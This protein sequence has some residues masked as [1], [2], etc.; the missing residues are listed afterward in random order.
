MIVGGI[1]AVVVLAVVYFLF[2]RGGDN[3]ITDALH[4][5][6]PA[7]PVPDFA[8]K[9]VTSKYEATQARMKKT[10]L[11]KA[12]KQ[13][14]PAVQDVIT[15]VLQAGYV[16]PDTWG[17]KGAI[18][19]YFTDDAAGQI[20]AK[21]N[22]LTLGQDVTFQT[23]TPSHNAKLKV[24]T[25]LDGNMQAVRAYGEFTFKAK[26]SNEDGSS[27]KIQLTGTF[28]LVPD[29]GDWKIEAF[30]LSR[31]ET[32]HKAHSPSGSA[33]GTGSPTATGSA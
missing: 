6:S 33:S 28:F 5:T 10:A 4:I 31:S 12:A 21:I 27:S 3:P 8:F 9:T 26:A 24:T 2:G 32:P 1:A 30:H 15:K 16:D 13:T 25:L 18:D 17:D 29:G 14:T 22:V 23:V 7:P 11:T 19:D 20:D